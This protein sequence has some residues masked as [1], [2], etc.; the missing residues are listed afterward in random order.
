MLKK[1]E[2]SERRCRE[3]KLVP[4]V[5]CP[6]AWDRSHV[7]RL[8]PVTKLTAQC[9]QQQKKTD[10][11]AGGEGIVFCWVSMSDQLY[12]QLSS[13]AGGQKY[14]S[15]PGG[16]WIE[17]SPFAWQTLQQF[18]LKIQFELLF[19][20]LVSNASDFWKHLHPILHLFIQNSARDSCCDTVAGGTEVGG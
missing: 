6:K 4:S 2:F 7:Q 1:S 8:K 10:G 11:I 5:L 18:S 3:K 14:L 17:P 19:A 13:T 20:A 9:Y 16:M 12:V 15:G